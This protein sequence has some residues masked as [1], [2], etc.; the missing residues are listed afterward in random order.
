MQ[1]LQQ[2]PAAAGRATRLDGP[3]TDSPRPSS[4]PHR[5]PVPAPF[6]NS[7]PP[8]CDASPALQ[9]LAGSGLGGDRGATSLE[10]ALRGAAAA[11][12]APPQPED[13]GLPVLELFLRRAPEGSGEAGTGREAPAVVRTCCWQA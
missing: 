13:V 5:R 11:D 6:L 7:P 1:V 10:A 12:A 3:L 4:T 2:A 8:P 9:E